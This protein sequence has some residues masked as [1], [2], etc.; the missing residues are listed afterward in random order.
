MTRVTVVSRPRA[1]R[2]VGG[3]RLRELIPLVLGSTKGL[4]EQIEEMKKTGPVW[5]EI[6]QN[7]LMAF[8]EATEMIDRTW[9]TLVQDIKAGVRR[10][11]SLL[12][13]L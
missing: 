2:L 9:E 4:G 7:K 5:D 3:G 11:G 10:L 12:R 8:H 6:T 13:S 1:E